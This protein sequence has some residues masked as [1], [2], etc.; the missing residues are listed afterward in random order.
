[1]GNA[2]MVG[3]SRA[4]LLHSAAARPEDLAVPPPWYRHGREVLYVAYAQQV[5]FSTSQ[6]LGGRP[7]GCQNFAC[8]QQQQQPGSDTMSHMPA[9][10]MLLPAALPPP[11]PT[12]STTHCDAPRP[13]LCHNNQVRVLQLHPRAAAMPAKN[14]RRAASSGEEVESGASCEQ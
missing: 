14:G 8:S 6:L 5:V 7:V 11:Q 1:M 12:A 2:G 3:G 9:C 10:C 13:A 4:G